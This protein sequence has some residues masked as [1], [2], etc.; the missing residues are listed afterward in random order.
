MRAR[1]SEKSG[2]KIITRSKTESTED[3]TKSGYVR[4]FITGKLLKYT[5]EEVVRQAVEK[6]L[7][8]DYGYSKDQMDIEFKIQRGSKKGNEE[9]DIVI[10]NDTKNKDQMNIYLVVETEA[11]EHDF[12]NQVISYV[13]ATPASFCMWANGKKTLFFY[14]S[15][16]NPTIFESLQQIPRKGETI[17]DIGRYLKTQLKPATNLKM[18]FENIHNQLYGSAN[19]RRAE[20]LGAEMTK[21][22]FCKIYDEKSLDLKCEFRATVDELITDDGID[23]IATRIKSI[24]VDVKKEYSDVFG[25]HEEVQLDN[26]SVALIV[27][28]LQQISLMKSDSD[29]VGNAFE[30]FVPDELKGTKGEFF[31]PRPVVRMAV[32]MISPD[33]TKKEKI[34]DPACG[35]GGFLTVAMEKVR[36]DLDRKYARSHLP[37][38]Q[39]EQI[40]GDYVRNYFYGI[41]VE[42]DLARIS[43]A[44]MAIIGDGRSGIFC[45]DSL[46]NP[47]KWSEVMQDK[48][49]FNT[50]DVLITN[51]PFG[52]KIAD[53]RKEVLEQ[54]DL[55]KFQKDSNGNIV[56]SNKTRRS[57]VPDILF[58]ERCFKLLKPSTNGKAG[59]RMAI[60]LPRG[61]L[62]N[63]D[64]VDDKA[65][66]KWLLDHMKILAV[67][68]LPR[69]TFR[70]HTNTVTSVLFAERTNGKIQD[71]YDVF[72]AI[73]R[74]IGHDKR[75]NP[76]FK[77]DKDGIPLL[78]ATGDFIIDI[79]TY[80]IEA[81]YRKFLNGMDFEDTDRSFTVSI[82]DIKKSDRLDA[83]Y[84]SPVARSAMEQIVSSVPKDWKLD[85]VKNITKDVF[86]P[87][88]FKRTYVDKRHGI[89]FLSGSNVTRFTK[90]G[91]KYLST[92][93]KN[94]DSYLVKKG[95]ILVTR[96]GTSGVIVY[97]DESFDNVAVSEHV[98]RIVPDESK[99]DGGYLFT[100]LNSEIYKPIFVSAI[101]GSMVD[102]ITPAFIQSIQIPVPENPKDDTHKQIGKKVKNA[103][104]KRVESNSLLDEA[105]HDLKQILN[106]PTSNRHETH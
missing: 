56:F 5:K 14:R 59:G 54:Y 100:V 48:I 93:T 36:A 94:L 97:A 92:K 87:A 79:D 25:E 101:T 28:K 41:D 21:L 63:P 69:D 105:Q 7:V 66:R 62:N 24:F 53:T 72:M 43:K 81:D 68:D 11:P 46:V 2:E 47:S 9:A 52:A 71:D 74:K 40:K 84:Y 50:F 19:I 67:V 60:V 77:R 32:G 82:N 13:T 49:T 89:P 76:I 78:D 31:T 44:Y 23:K 16:K 42:Q 10:F 3:L 102:E 91:V 106:K 45:D 83:S 85:T 96:S 73:S 17:N 104:R 86:Y 57:Q 75:G 18:I 20:K 6:M 29:T 12:D 4:D 33:G 39:I 8:D 35:S 61:I 98:I 99:I 1:R 38:K 65:A 26:H 55:A 103:E 37:E 70:P 90:V 51:P 88:R 95:W 15:P 64:K 30:V 22:L 58:L 34:I 80:E 27:S